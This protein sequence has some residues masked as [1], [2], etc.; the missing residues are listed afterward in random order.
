MN[1]N[2]LAGMFHFLVFVLTSRGK[3]KTEKWKSFGRV[4]LFVTLWT[5]QSVNSP[6]Q[7]TG[8]G[9]LCLLKAHQTFC[10]FCDCFFS[11]VLFLI[12]EDGFSFSRLSDLIPFYFPSYHSHQVAICFCL[13][14]PSD[15][16]FSFSSLCHFEMALMSIISSILLWFNAS[17]KTQLSAGEVN[18]GKME[19]FTLLL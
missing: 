7:N 19:A 10:F 5:L 14:T 8:V 11:M 13:H 9:S 2:N 12:F 17:S 18:C 4:Q 15:R 6:G 1:L 16:E 3:K